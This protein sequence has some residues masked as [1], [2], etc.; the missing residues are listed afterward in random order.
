MIIQGREITLKDI[1]LIR[2]MISSHPSWGRTRISK[3]LG[4]WIKRYSHPIFLLESFVDKERF[5]GTCYRASN[6]IYVGQTKGRGRNDRHGS[7]KVPIKDIYLL[8]LVKRFRE[9]LTCSSR[10]L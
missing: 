1:A 3:E 6:W 9:I 7:L 4:D 10:S 2:E 8:P 5:K